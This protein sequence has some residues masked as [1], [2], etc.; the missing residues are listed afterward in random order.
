[1]M[2][3]LIDPITEDIIS[4]DI[5]SEDFIAEIVAAEGKIDND[6]YA[7]GTE[8]T[9]SGATTSSSSS[10]TSGESISQTM[11][12]SMIEIYEGSSHS[13][14]SSMMVMDSGSMTM[15]SSMMTMDS[16]S[17]M[18]HHH[19]PVHMLLSSGEETAAAI[20]DGSWFD[21]NTWES[22]V[23]P[24]DGAKVLIP[25]GITVSYDQESQARIDTIRVD[26]GLIFAHDHNTKLIVDTLFS[27]D[28]GLL[29]IGTNEHPIQA[30]KTTQIIIDS[31][32]AVSDAMQLGK[33]V[34]L[35]G[36]TRIHG[37]EKLDFVN[38]QNAQAGDN[39][40]VLS[41][42][43]GNIT[44]E[45]WRIGD[46]LVLGGTAYNATGSDADNSRFQDEVLTITAIN[47]NEISFT[48][49]DITEGDNTVLRFDHN[50][51]Q[52]FEDQVN[53]YVANTTRNV[54]IRTEN[55]ENA[56]INNRG[57]VMFMHNDDVQV[58]NAGFYELGRSNKNEIVDDLVTN[59]DGSE[60]TGTNIRGR[61]ALHF[62]RSGADD[63]NSTPAIASGNAVVGSPGWGI[64]H[65]DS[66][67]ILEDNVVFDVL[68]AGI[69]AEAGNEIGRWSNNIT[70]K[71]TGDNDPN[72][73]FDHSKARVKNFDMGFN[74]EGYWLQGAGQILMTDNVAVS[75]AGAG[76]AVFGG[77]DGGVSARDKQ[78]IQVSNLPAEWQDIA[79]GR[80]DESV[81]D[82]AAVPLLGVS[83]FEV[84]NS[85]KGILTWGSMLNGDGQLSLDVP[86]SNAV[87]TAVPAHDYRSTIDDFQLWNIRN[88]GV[89]LWYTSQ[90][91]LSNGLILADTTIHPN[92]R[93]AG[94][95]NND[96]NHTFTNLHIEDFGIGIQLPNDYGGNTGGGLHREIISSV[97]KDSYI[98]GDR[99]N[100]SF[101]DNDNHYLQLE[102][103]TFGEINNSTNVSPSESFS[104]TEIGGLAYRFDA[105]ASYDADPWSAYSKYETQGIV[106]YG[107][108]FD[109]DSV[110]DAF[111]KEIDHDFAATGPQSV[112]LTVWD[113]LGQATTLSQTIDVQQNAY[114]NAFLN[115][116]FSENS[117]LSY[118]SGSSVYA[119]AGWGK[120]GSAYT[121]ADGTFVLSDG[122]DWSAAIGQ[123]VQ[124]DYMSRGQQTLSV[125]LK[126][127]NASSAYYERNEISLS[128][129]GVN[130]QFEN[131]L[132][133]AG[134]KQ[135]GALEMESVQLLN[136][137]LGDS[138]SNEWQMLSWEL[139]FG[140]GY[141]YL[142]AEI[143]MK[144]GNQAGDYVAIDNF[145]LTSD[146]AMELGASSLATDVSGF[147]NAET[148]VITGTSSLLNTT[149]T[150]QF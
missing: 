124:D 97:I 62:H 101:F 86:G 52:E 70:I 45:G 61:Y 123:V 8:P 105:S 133:A 90:Y 94:V 147:Q 15:D 127:I 47:G 107:W 66:H 89:Q 39:K 67:A 77:A 58:K 54:S 22:G 29:Q 136:V 130:G 85:E 10:S 71:T 84:Y 98:S 32:D 142:L 5:I 146:G 91:D 140:L 3:N 125:E 115:G 73:G 56:P 35:S 108:D 69:V 143:H 110:I 65:H 23:V 113:Q 109:N 55:G 132:S 41:L 25:E 26:G 87:E 96:K 20:N 78:T 40:L 149:T 64:V 141:Q 106:A 4:E 112:S 30:D 128:V 21:P 111:G 68:G 34:V 42:P 139:D 81:V 1:M 11:L 129:W 88:N 144:K 93:G 28:N 7:T 53:L 9:S 137:E 60:G 122:N 44:P 46:Q 82:V 33:G 135:S 138:D 6:R 99:T 12:Q 27:T 24:S 92:G 50:Q 131:T 2:N 80:G 102:N 74:G 17:I 118:N 117:F 37:A 103:N 43:P 119:D 75:A 148:D 51:P 95:A 120:V 145:M 134:P 63:I 150:A 57:H 121:N 14:H 72:E 104:V 100:F 59:K 18:D 83:G 114:D 31:Q 48:N 36:V 116:D 38:L 19:H 79:K 76:L 16:G 13:S 126:N 49:N